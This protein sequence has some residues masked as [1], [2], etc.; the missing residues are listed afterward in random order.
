MIIFERQNT[1]CKRLQIITRGKIVHAAT[2][3]T[4]ST[5]YNYNY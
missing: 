3:Q 4:T 2:K 1:I 5:C